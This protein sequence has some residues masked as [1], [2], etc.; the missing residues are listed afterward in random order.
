MLLQNSLKYIVLMLV[1]IFLQV[2]VFNNI[3][4]GGYA[5]PY[6]YIIFILLF[7]LDKNRFVTLILAFI[8]GLSIDFL[9]NTGGVNA[10]ASVFTAYIRYYV[11]AL[12][13][14]NTA[15]DSDGPRLYNLNFVQWALYLGLMIFI[16]HFM[17]DF[18]E[19]FRVSM[20][21]Q[22]AFKALLGSA[23]TFVLTVVYLFFFPVAGRN[24]Y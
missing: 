13:T 24:E 7:P 20:S 15:Q 4:F 6:F 10:F 5:N 18:M 12:L 14:A 21:G 11:V 23:L 2:A 22:I 17:V 8:L 3:N 16:H 19:S 1:L 9:E